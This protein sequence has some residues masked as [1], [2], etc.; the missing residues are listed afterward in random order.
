MR[1]KTL[2]K[3][4]FHVQTKFQLQMSLISNHRNHVQ[5]CPKNSKSCLKQNSLFS[6][7]IKPC[8]CLLQMN[9]M[10]RRICRRNFCTCSTRPWLF[11]GLGN[12]GDKYK[13]TRHNVTS[14]SGLTLLSWKDCVKPD[15][16][17]VPFYSRSSLR[18]L[19]L[20]SALGWFWNAWCIC[21][22]TRNS[23]GDSTL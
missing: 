14:I 23:Y 4:K 21:R 7:F 6:F 18:A 8:W 12:P 16:L 17:W 15:L 5:T 20:V 13:G 1:T 10:L 9:G 3:L 22:F 19:S 11:V 2:R